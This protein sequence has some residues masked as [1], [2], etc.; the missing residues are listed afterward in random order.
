M[1]PG[2]GG[3]FSS[4]MR[5]VVRD[6]LKASMHPKEV[7]ET[8][9]GQP[10]FR[11]GSARSCSHREVEPPILVELSSATR[12]GVTVGKGVG[13]NK[14]YPKRDAPAK[15]GQPKKEKWLWPD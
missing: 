8:L 2:S 11:C 9:V 10:C 6:T 12:P 7:Y 14:R 1:E 13:F 15:R 4:N 3:L 5:S